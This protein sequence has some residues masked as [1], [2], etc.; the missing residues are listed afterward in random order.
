LSEP[1]GRAPVALCDHCGAPTVVAEDMVA[2]CAHCGRSE[3]L[4]KP[5]AERLAMLH[6][7]VLRAARQ[8]QI[9]S[10]SEL[11][12]VRIFEG[13]EGL[14]RVLTFWGC[15]GLV[16]A[17]LVVVAGTLRSHSF[18][19][20][21]TFLVL[22]VPC[23]IAA[24]F[25]MALLAGR[26]RYRATV[27]DLLAARRP[28]GSTGGWT[29]R[30]CTGPVVHDVGAVVICAS[31]G[32]ANLVSRIE[33]ARQ[34]VELYARETYA[35]AQREKALTLVGTLTRHMR[36]VMIATFVVGSVVTLVATIALARVFG[37]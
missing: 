13:P 28:A 9:V 12:Y 7:R 16:P 32:V 31:C 24:G 37:P 20:A 29:C 18:S 27:R 22:M 30:V 3:S 2:H 23:T 26:R 34:A 21:L 15:V 11:G 25:S 4:P 14:R 19:A 36:R 5:T 17:A 1:A 6:A 35:V 8:R 33:H 10:S